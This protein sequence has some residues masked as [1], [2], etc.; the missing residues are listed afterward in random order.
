MHKIHYAQ[1]WE[2]PRT[3]EKALDIG[4]LDHVLSIASGGDNSLALL[5]KSPKSLITIDKNPVQIYLVELKIKA[6]QILEYDDFLFF[7]GARPSA[8]RKHLYSYLRPHLREQAKS[9]WDTHSEEISSGIIHCGKFEQYFNYF[10]KLI[11]PFIHRNSTVRQLLSLT[12]LIQQHTF[13]LRVWNNRRWQWLFH[14]FFGKFILG[15]LGRDPSLF[16]YVT[17][18]HIAEELFRRTQEGLTE[19]PIS[20]NF[21]LEYIFTGAFGNIEKAHPYL[22]E[23]NFHIL[24]ENVGKMKT[25][26]ASLEHYLDTL[27]DASVTKFN[28]SD[29]FEYLPDNSYE[30]LLEKIVRVSGIGARMAFWTLFVPRIIPERLLDEIHPDNLLAN[31]LFKMNRTFFYGNFCVWNI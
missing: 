11:L 3:L 27:P 19:V 14:I 18:D 7:I 16:R 5:L 12:S 20:D 25:V 24:K 2:D 4:P 22:R 6:I 26:I 1:C 15:H 9:Y 8:S 21:F 10:R 30:N 28:L 31:Q 29:I 23:K 17:L 13:Y